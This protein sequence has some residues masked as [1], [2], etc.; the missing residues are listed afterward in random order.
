[1]IPRDE[2]VKPSN[3]FNDCLRRCENC[4]VG[5]SNGKNNP[6]M[7]YK[8]YI[9]NVP[10]LLRHDLDF[11]LNNSLNLINRTNKKSKFAFS[12]SEDAL[13]WSFFK[14]F[15]VKKRYQDLL[16]LLNIDSE[17][18][19][20]DLNL[21]GTNI[22]SQNIDSDLLRQIIQISDSFNEDSNKRTEPDVIIKLRDK[23]IF[24][25]VKYLSSND[26]KTDSKK[27]DKYLVP[28]ID[29]QELTES[30]HYEL[31]RNW[32]FI[33]KLSNGAKFQLINL[34]M[35]RLF[36]DKN[37]TRLKQFE[38]SLHSDS[39]S[40]VKLSWEQIIRNMKENDYDKWF[41]EYLK[42][43]IKMPDANTRS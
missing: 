16:K 22:C 27:F 31:F 37:M 29:Y 12:T 7:I 24:I 9:D 42:Q 41:V 13:T 23:L 26:V 40:F 34:G 35:Q 3:S 11:V 19:K 18:S 28:D 4:M 25:E 33:A 21:W 17:E 5:F 39:G 15:V 8:N 20:Y 1:M 36:T 14:Y 2:I 43:K 32:A 38:N 6:T 30:G 10:E